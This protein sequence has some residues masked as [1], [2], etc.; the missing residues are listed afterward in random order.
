MISSSDANLM[1]QVRASGQILRAQC[2]RY[3]PSLN[4][5]Y[6]PI[7][8]VM[9]TEWIDV[10]SVVGLGGWWRTRVDVGLYTAI[11]TPEASGRRKLQVRR[12]AWI[13]DIESTP[14]PSVVQLRSSYSTVMATSHV[15]QCWHKLSRK[16]AQAKC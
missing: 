7:L 11:S 15:A 4:A 1:R 5:S 12:I 10:L 2:V 8:S 14:A 13:I 16:L 6:G 3:T 9:L